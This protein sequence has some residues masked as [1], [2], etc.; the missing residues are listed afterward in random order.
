[1]F[2]FSTSNEPERVFFWANITICMKTE[3]SLVCMVLCRPPCKG[4]GR[5]DGMEKL[6]PLKIHASFHYSHFFSL[7]LS[8]SYV[9]PSESHLL[10][11]F[12]FLHLFFPSPEMTKLEIRESLSRKRKKEIKSGN[13]EVMVFSSFA[14]FSSRLST[15]LGSS[16]IFLSQKVR[17]SSPAS[18]CRDLYACDQLSNVPNATHV[19]Y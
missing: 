15:V 10:T 2:P 1:M 18:S 19:D 13:E 9:R 3:L 4:K 12:F 7:L 6:P 14:F 5:T 8:R 11:P 17:I 16:L